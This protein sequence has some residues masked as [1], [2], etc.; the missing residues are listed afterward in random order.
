MIVRES[1]PI[2]A[3]SSKMGFSRKTLLLN[4]AVDSNGKINHSIAQAHFNS[5]ITQHSTG[6]T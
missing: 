3:F 5:P 6:R 4:K 1:T 2:A